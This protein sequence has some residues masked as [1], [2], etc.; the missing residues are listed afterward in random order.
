[1]TLSMLLVSSAVGSL[2]FLGISETDPLKMYEKG[3]S[4]NTSG[5]FFLKNCSFV[6][7]HELR[8]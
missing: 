6:S 2:L 4:R 8:V 1:M 5:E 7:Q 3:P